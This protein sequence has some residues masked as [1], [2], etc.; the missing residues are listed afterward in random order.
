M[1]FLNKLQINLLIKT[2][3]NR[4]CISSLEFYTFKLLLVTFNA[5]FYMAGI[6]PF[7]HH[8]ETKDRIC[9]YRLSTN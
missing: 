1:D 3:R 4:T 5:T 7:E 9:T 8:L 2:S 6:L